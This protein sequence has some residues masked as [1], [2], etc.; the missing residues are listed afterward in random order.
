MPW[1]YV[2]TYVTYKSKS[3]DILLNWIIPKEEEQVKLW[4]P[5]A[6]VNSSDEGLKAL[7]EG[8]N[9]NSGV[10]SIRMIQL[11]KW[12]FPENYSFNSALGLFLCQCF[13]STPQH[14]LIYIL[15]LDKKYLTPP[16]TNWDVNIHLDK[17]LSTLWRRK[18]NHFLLL[19]NL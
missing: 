14:F 4:K 1:T 17:S 3:G 15:R 16:L 2:L 11:Q 10:A 19:H 9:T 8:S 5:A 13:N 12:S 7:K 18:T 6:N